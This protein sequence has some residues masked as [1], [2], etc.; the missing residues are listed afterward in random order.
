ME[1][2]N[3][4][5][6]SIPAYALNSMGQ[7]DRLQVQEHLRLCASCRAELD[8]YQ[9]VV[10]EL[11]YAIPRAIPP[12]DLKHKI[13]HSLP[14]KRVPVAQ[15]QPASVWQRLWGRQRSFSPVWAFTS[16]FLVIIL[17]ASN[18][19]LWQRV[20][21]LEASSQ[22]GFQVV[23]LAGTDKAPQASGM[24]V[25]SHDGDM[26]TLV[27][28]SLPPLDDAH[29]YQIWLNRDGQRANGGVFSVSKDGYGALRILTNEPL[30]QFKTFGITIE[31]TGGSTEPTGDKVLA[32]SL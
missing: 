23:A 14:E 18:L 12:A 28:D 10:E 15:T 27:V 29:Q 1:A 3:H 9:R 5:L 24:L 22:A 2:E 8:A 21:K 31:P 4:V 17:A 25:I 16:L 19:W 32:G 6:E 11:A 26:G 7:E 13:L 20:S 30:I